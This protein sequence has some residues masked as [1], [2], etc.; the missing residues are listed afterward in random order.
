MARLLLPAPRAD[1]LAV[2]PRFDVDLDEGL[3][4]R[5]FDES[6]RL[7]HKRLVRLD[8]IENTLEVH[9]AVAPEKGLIQATASF[10]ER[11]RRM[12]PSLME[13]LKRAMLPASDALP[14][15]ALPRS[16]GRY[17]DRYA[18]SMPTPPR[19][20]RR[21][22]GIDLPSSQNVCAIA[23]KTSGLAAEPRTKRVPS[24]TDSAEDPHF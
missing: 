1:R 14:Q 6:Y 7:V 15:A 10:T 11:R 16:G 9:P 18:C 22:W 21:S 4:I 13:C 23:H 17:R 8:A 2:R 19:R 20:H 3:R 5:D 12:L 24:P